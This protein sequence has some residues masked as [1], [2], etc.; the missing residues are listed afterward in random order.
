MEKYKVRLNPKAYTDIDRIFF[1][2]ALFKI[3]E[4]N[5]IVRVVTVQYQGRNM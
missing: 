1:Y 5:K 3:D 2:I 4:T